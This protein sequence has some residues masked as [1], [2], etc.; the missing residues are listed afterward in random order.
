METEDIQK[1]ANSKEFRKKIFNTLT[2]FAIEG[3]TV[4]VSDLINE[5]ADN[6][7]DALAMHKG[8]IVQGVLDKLRDN[9]IIG[10]HKDKNEN[11]KD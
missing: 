6:Y 2:N 1:E 5:L 8:I 10:L 7:N 4:Q 11:T 3:K 9:G